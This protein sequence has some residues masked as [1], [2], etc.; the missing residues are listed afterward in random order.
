[1]ARSPRSCRGSSRASQASPNTVAAYRDTC[2]L[3][4]DFGW[5]STCSSQPPGP[6]RPGR[7]LIAGFLQHLRTERAKGTTRN[8]RLAALRSLFRYAALLATC[9]TGLRVSELTSLPVAD[10][11]RGTGAQVRCRGKS[12]KGRATPLTR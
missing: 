5:R 6:L 9:Q 12:R 2:R 11:H 1:M 8:A 7:P 3:L 4:L 10:M